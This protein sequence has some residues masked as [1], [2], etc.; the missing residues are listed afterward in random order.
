MFLETNEKT[1]WSLAS[2]CFTSRRQHIY[3][4]KQLLTAWAIMTKRDFYTEQ[5]W[6]IYDLCYTVANCLGDHDKTGLL[7][8]ATMADL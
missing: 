6:L 3:F 4:A 7:Y 5:P 2:K 1:V 8:G